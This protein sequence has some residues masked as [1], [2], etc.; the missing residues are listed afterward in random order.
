MDCVYVLNKR[1]RS[2]W[3]RSARIWRQKA[4][5]RNVAMAWLVTFGA[6][7]ISVIVDGVAF[8]FGIFFTK[9]LE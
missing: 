5:H 6:F 1:C 8:S 3:R 2:K 4:K 7:M 9:L